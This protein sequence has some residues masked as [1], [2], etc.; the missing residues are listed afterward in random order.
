MKM[1][2]I[3]CS[4]CWGSNTEILMKEALVSGAEAYPTAPFSIL[5]DDSFC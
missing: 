5:V 4:P 3:V 2:S 1:M